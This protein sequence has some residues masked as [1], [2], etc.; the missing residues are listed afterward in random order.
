MELASC[1]DLVWNNF[2][3]CQLDLVLA[4]IAIIIAL[5]ASYEATFSGTWK[6]TLF[7]GV[8]ETNQMF[9]IIKELKPL[10]KL[11]KNFGSKL[12][13]S[14]ITVHLHKPQHTVEF[15]AAN[16]IQNTARCE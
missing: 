7:P 3:E 15:S 16:L 12:S 5:S 10:Q 14:D 13:W 6:K 11:I 4:F 2:A 1:E 9:V 8:D